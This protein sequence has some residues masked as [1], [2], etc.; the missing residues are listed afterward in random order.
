MRVVSKDPVMLRTRFQCRYCGNDSRH[1]YGYGTGGARVSIG[2]EDV[3]VV[4]LVAVAAVAAVAV[5]APGAPGADQ[6]CQCW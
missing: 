1:H 2:E 3:L 6:R 5:V 4:V